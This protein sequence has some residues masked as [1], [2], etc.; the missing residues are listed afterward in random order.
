MDKQ[1]ISIAKKIRER[2]ESGTYA[3]GAPIPTRMKLAKS[4]GVARPT[5]DRCIEFLTANGTLISRQGSGT[6][7]SRIRTYS[8]RLAL[9]SASNIISEFP[10]ISG[11]I[12]YVPLSKASEKSSFASLLKFDGLLWYRPEESVLDCI[13]DFK[14]KL[15][16]V[17][18]NRTI[19]GFNCVSTDHRGAY[20]EITTERI[21]AFPKV[22]PCFLSSRE[23][24]GGS[25]VTVYRE[26]GFVD[27]CR[28]KKRFYEI[29]HM[30][31]GFEEMIKTLENHLSKKEGRPL[32]VVSDSI[33]NTGA[34]VFWARKNGLTWKK[35]LFYSD[36]DNIYP[37]NV[38]GV[39][40]TS[41]IQDDR[42]VLST[43]IDRLM[44]IVEGRDK[45]PEHLLIFPKRKNGE[46]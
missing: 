37:S 32:I 25:L 15:P 20:R 6:Y 43:S 38:W 13:Q 39:E 4:F 46:T 41:Y 22:S 36:F 17:I 7:V 45:G 18:I 9:I 16:Q 33:M 29:I 11:Q 26:S 35:D 2:V 5:I 12:T 31:L 21:S 24:Q 44:D 34:F 40:V 27:A 14:D 19:E 28:R 30:P 3:P 1:Y 42:L 10:E 8:R 23:A